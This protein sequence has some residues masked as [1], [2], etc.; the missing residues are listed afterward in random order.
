MMNSLSEHDGMMQS[1]S[2]SMA[3]LELTARKRGRGDCTKLYGNEDS[4][5][6]KCIHK[7]ENK[8]NNLHREDD[9]QST[10]T[11]RKH[12]I[13]R[14]KISDNNDNQKLK[15]FSRRAARVSSRIRKI[16][17]P[18]IHFT[19]LIAAAI[20]GDYEK[21]K[22]ELREIRTFQIFAME[23]DYETDPNELEKGMDFQHSLH[24]GSVVSK[25]S[26]LRY[27]CYY[28]RTKIIDL[29]LNAGAS[30]MDIELPRE[31]FTGN[32][33]DM[34]KREE[35]RRRRLAFMMGSISKES[36]LFRACFSN[37][38]YDKNAVHIIFDF[39]GKPTIE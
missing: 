39:M 29:L 12:N 4:V 6:E 35:Y 24:D 33:R 27:A 31:T 15:E 17:Y 21:V 14:K 10:S 2:A 38:L 20:E 18:R 28:S 16:K 7:D 5:N 25:W 30:I 34:I 13:K 37:A 9:E 32:V 22:S 26:A 1:P 11:L 8:M 19:P 36:D 23:G 3:Q